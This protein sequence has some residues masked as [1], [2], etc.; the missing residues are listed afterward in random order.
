[1]ITYGTVQATVATADE[2]AGRFTSPVCVASTGSTCTATA[3]Q[4]TTINPVAAA[5]IKDIFSKVPEPGNA[6]THALFT[7]LRNVFNHRQ[8]LVRIDHVFGPKLSVSGRYLNDSIP[9]EEPGEM[10]NVFNHTNFN[11]VGT[12]FGSTTFGQILSTRDPRIVQLALKF[13][14]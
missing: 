13:Y 12:S 7:P 1:M 2:K 4:I 3:T 9:T 14:Y 11:G 6:T 5:Y 8:E 10:F